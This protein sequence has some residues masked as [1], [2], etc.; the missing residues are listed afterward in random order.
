MP[1][2]GGFRVG[3]GRPKGVKEPEPRTRQNPENSSPAP[4]IMR[5]AINAGMTPLEYM[6]AVM[7]DPD[8][9]QV[10]R[11]RMAMAAAPYCHGRMSDNRVGKKDQARI[12]AATASEDS[13][14]AYDGGGQLN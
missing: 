10:R 4:D 13:D 8:A 3:A 11:D 7:R 1:K 12:D 5:A 2:R 6:L 9:E 14:L